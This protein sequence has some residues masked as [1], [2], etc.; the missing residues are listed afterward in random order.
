MLLQQTPASTRQ[1]TAPKDTQPSTNTTLGPRIERT[2][3]RPQQV[4]VLASTTTG[5]S[6]SSQKRKLAVDS[7]DFLPKRF[8]LNFNPPMIIL[9]YMMKSK[10]KLYLSKIKLY[11]LQAS[12]PSDLALK[13]IKDRYWELFETGK[14]SDKQI[15]SLVDKLKSKLSEQAQSRESHFSDSSVQAL[16]QERIKAAE[17]SAKVEHAV[18]EPEEQPRKSSSKQV[19]KQ[20]L[21][22]ATDDI[23]EGEL[24]AEASYYSAMFGT[25]DSSVSGQ[26]RPKPP[27][28]TTD[29]GSL[30]RAS[31]QTEE[32]VVLGQEPVYSQPVPSEVSALV[33]LNN[34]LKKNQPSNEIQTIPTHQVKTNLTEG[35]SFEK[36]E[37]EDD[38]DDGSDSERGTYAQKQD[39]RVRQD[40]L[41]AA[42]T[43]TAQ[44]APSYSLLKNTEIPGKKTPLFPDRPRSGMPQNPLLSKLHQL[45]DEE[46]G[47]LDDFEDEDVDFDE[48]EPGRQENGKSREVGSERRGFQTTGTQN[49]L[50]D[51]VR[52]VNGQSIDRELEEYGDQDSGDKSDA[53][54]YY[55]KGESD[56]EEP[57]L[58]EEEQADRSDLG[59]EY[60]EGWTEKQEQ[61]LFQRVL[62]DIGAKK[63]PSVV[64]EVGEEEEEYSPRNEKHTHH[65]EEPEVNENLVESGVPR[66][67][68]QKD[69]SEMAD[70]MADEYADEFADQFEPE[71]GDQDAA[72]ELVRPGETDRTRKKIDSFDDLGSVSFDDLEPA[73]EEHGEEEHDYEKEDEDDNAIMNR[74]LEREREYLHSKG[75]NSEPRLE[76]INLNKLNDKEVAAVKRIMDQ[77]CHVLKPGDEGYVYEV[78]KSFD[79][80]EES[81]EWDKSSKADS[82]FNKSQIIGYQKPSPEISSRTP[83]RPSQP[84]EA[85][86]V[87]KA[88]QIGLPSQKQ[89][90]PPADEEFDLDFDGDEDFNDDLDEFDDE[91]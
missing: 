82:H 54:K 36:D 78:E 41:L 47:D 22:T 88:L 23:T 56:D 50:R 48:S 45:A 3:S 25:P 71:G 4:S 27:E 77:M 24:P 91:T 83:K 6:Q 84:V 86:P 1:K 59:P 44:T 40:V 58:G 73:D 67:N 66:L 60:P 20:A 14:I 29:T 70:K 68:L 55:S 90:A 89:R 87:I 81:N 85:S 32:E 2:S 33:K 5:K 46:F 38:E 35:R 57:Q 21:L 9:E 61:E 49:G 42:R 80:A 63:N 30:D 62:G 76:K 13:Y 34:F 8:A 65:I 69:S 74:I 31:K 16:I 64:Q 12:T 11:K 75:T 72:A 43:H 26:S 51:A 53:D 52:Q 28:S 17:R 15:I 39:H 7:E 18:P 79:P 19:S 37:E 10:G